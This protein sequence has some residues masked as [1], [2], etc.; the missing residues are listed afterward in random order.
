MSLVFA[1]AIS[2]SV[3]EELITEF[4]LIILVK[5][6]IYIFGFRECHL[7]IELVLCVGSG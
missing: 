4:S 1:R 7:V 2:P 5:R 6:I 3:G